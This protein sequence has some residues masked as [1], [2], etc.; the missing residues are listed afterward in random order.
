M[1]KPLVVELH[2]VISSIHVNTDI[3]EKE[4]VEAFQRFLDDNG[5]MFGG[6]FVVE[7]DEE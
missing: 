3:T 7:P 4:F 2:G 1:S 5:Y 6:G